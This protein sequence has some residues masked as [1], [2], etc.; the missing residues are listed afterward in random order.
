MKII[1]LDPRINNLE[2]T[3]YLNELRQSFPDIQGY[4][5]FE[6][7]SLPSE[8]F[9]LMVS[10]KLIPKALDFGQTCWNCIEILI[11]TGSAAY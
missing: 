7:V 8:P 2:N 3:N 9:V 1:W 5:T 4:S 10:A 11:F 6:Q